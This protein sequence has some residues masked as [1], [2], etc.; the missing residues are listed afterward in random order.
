MIKVFLSSTSKDLVPFRERAIEVITGIDGHH[1][2]A[3]ENFGARDA[4]AEDFC[5][6]E[7]AAC[8]LFILLLGPT[9]GSCP[10]GS[11]QSYTHLEYDKAVELGKPRLVFASS[12][13]FHIS[14]QLLN[15]V[16]PDQFQKQK[17]FRASF[18]A[19]RI[20]GFFATPDELA[21]LISNAIQNR[22]AEVERDSRA[23]YLDYLIRNNSDVIVRGV[24]QTTRQ[25]SVR[26]DE[27]Y[28]SLRAEREFNARQDLE[29]RFKAGVKWEAEMERS[30]ASVRA[31]PEK[32]T[33]RLDWAQA[34][35]DHRRIVVLGDPGAGKTTLMRFLAMQFARA[36]RD[37]QSAVQDKEGNEYGPARLPIL[38]RVSEYADA[39]REDKSLKLKRFLARAFE[40]V[41]APRPAI[42]RLLEES[43]RRGEALILLDGLDEVIDQ[44][45]RSRIVHEIEDLVSNSH[46][47]NRVV[48]T[49]RIAGYAAARLDGRY[50]HFTLLDL[51]REQIEKF[52]T[53]WCNAAERFL[54]SEATDK[55]VAC[56][57]QREIDGILKAVD[58]NPGVKRLAVNPLLLT[59]L[60]MIHRN[61]AR[62]PNRRVKL[63]EM[64]AESLLEDWQMAK[65]IASDKTIREDEAAQFL[66]PLA[67]WMHSEKP[68]GLASEREVKE[69]LAE[70]LSQTRNLPTDHPDVIAKVNDFLDRVQRVTGVFVERAPGEYGFLHLTFEEYF[71]A[72]ELVR[73]PQTAAR[74]IHPLRHDPRWREPILLAIGFASQ[75]FPDL[76]SS[77][78]RTA[79]LAEGEEAALLKCKPSQYE[80]ILHRDLLLAAR[81]LGDDVRVDP[82]LQ[83]QIV[84]Q[85][86]N[87][88]FAD[89]SPKVL[90]EDIQKVF[91]SLAG[92]FAN[93]DV[94][95]FL[96]RRL[97]DSAPSLRSAAASALEA[98]EERAVSAGLIEKLLAL[99]ADTEGTVRSA[100][101]SALGAMG[102]QAASEDVIEKLLGLLASTEGAVRSAAASALGSVGE[103]AAREDVIEK[104]LGSLADTEEAVRSAAAS[105]LGAMGGQAASEDV[106]E[107]LLGLL[108]DTEWSVRRDAS[109]SLG[110]LWEQ[111]VAEGVVEKLADLLASSERDVQDAAL[112]TLGELGERVASEDVIEKLLSLLSNSDWGIRFIASRSLGMLGEPAASKDVIEKL[113][114]F[115]AHDSKHV[116]SGAALALEQF[117]ER[118]A[119]EEVI[120]KLFGL[121]MDSDERVRSDAAKALGELGER[122]A[123]DE[124]IDKLLDMLTDSS[125]IARSGAA[126]ALN[127]MGERAANEAVI[128]RLLGLLADS[129]LYVVAVASN[130]LG[131]MGERAARED[132]IEKLLGLLAGTAWS[133]ALRALESL[134]SKVVPA[135]RGGVAALALPF[136]R[137]RGKSDK[138][139]DQR[140]AGYIVLRNVMAAG[141][142]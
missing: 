96:E 95:E 57:A 121:L 16:Q 45:D 113:I 140:N 65:G 137:K 1:C 116:R 30:L 82:L 14:Q 17:A 119:S 78:I 49:S 33:E 87:L 125:M 129:S 108:A 46:A 20:R 133:E 112:R 75:G 58:D 106:I 128:E 126:W 122:A 76:P 105:A 131:A 142:E 93:D 88:Y 94:V 68:S 83:R 25:V 103:R 6:D 74:K 66:W 35:R 100:A 22:K 114:G 44:S 99:L 73:N 135:A 56:I 42:A 71:A 32:R 111:A 59:I 31:I 97:S 21:A 67:F 34:V 127:S 19:D 50:Q 136:A 12:D 10:H 61:G 28:V 120:E 81:V 84:A 4:A 55:E 101:A 27:I 51:E 40:H 2:I 77:L 43:L 118:V 5:R 70:V 90:C 104:L 47:D 107:K 62:L 139:R 98:M 18:G 85:L 8:D 15:A 134:S 48:V 79:I 91:T 102:G 13:Q 86:A 124:V 38:F 60:A 3:M 37:G 92:T 41:D 109:Y 72:R 26:L 7:V 53:R 110:Q 89:S 138:V 117:G 39:I 115:L 63:Y 123:S 132:V 29:F 80:S 9:Y 36:I 69:K 23:A 64:A 24:R 141:T 11:D 54:S 130:A 52:L